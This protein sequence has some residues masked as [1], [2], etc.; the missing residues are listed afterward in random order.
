MQGGEYAYAIDDMPET[1]GFHSYQDESRGLCLSIG[2]HTFRASD[3]TG[4]GWAGGLFSVREKLTGRLLVHES[5]LEEGNRTIH[6]STQTQ[7]S[8]DSEV[9]SC[10]GGCVPRTFVGDGYCDDD[11][12][13]GL[14]PT[15]RTGYHLDCRENSFVSSI[16]CIRESATD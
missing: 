3:Q 2:N 4:S 9:V 6:F 7:C 1:T 8:S 11:L 10:V 14:M 12:H 15:Q 5:F 13:T 16:Q